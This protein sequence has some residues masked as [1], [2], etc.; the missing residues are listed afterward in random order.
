MHSD[1]SVN[2]VVRH[3]GCQW[4]LHVVSLGNFAG[5][6]ATAFPRLWGEVLKPD[7]WVQWANSYIFNILWGMPNL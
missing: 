2:V 4:D 1:G 5:E 7:I 3:L 6:K